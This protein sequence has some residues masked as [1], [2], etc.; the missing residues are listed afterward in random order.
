M[1]AGMASLSTMV[2]ST[3][4]GDAPPHPHPN[5]PLMAFVRY[6]VTRNVR[7]AGSLELLRTP[8]SDRLA[9]GSPLFQLSSGLPSIRFL[10]SF[11][12]IGSGSLPPLK[13]LALFLLIS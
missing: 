13:R 10:R 5:Q 7:N 6:L 1:L 11:L 8:L 12:V 4:N 9:G 3:S 2:G